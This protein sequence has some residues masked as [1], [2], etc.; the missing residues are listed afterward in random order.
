MPIAGATADLPVIRDLDAYFYVRHR[1][2]ALLVGAFEPDG[3][4]LDPASLP[5][6]FSFGE[7]EPDWDHFAPVRE[8]AEERIPALRGI[9]WARVPERAREFT[10]DADFCIGETGAVG[11]LYVAAGF[12]S[13][14]IMFAA[15]AGRALAEWIVAGTPQTTS[16]GST[17][18]ASRRSSRTA[19]TSTTRVKRGPRP[20]VRVALAVPAAAHGAQHP[21]DAAAR[22]GPKRRTPVRRDSSAGSAPTGMRRRRAAPEY[23]YSFGRQNWF[24]HAAAEHHAVRNAR[25]CIDLSTFTKFEVAG[26]DAL[27]VLQWICTKD[28]DVAV[29]RVVYTLMLNESGGIE[30]DGTVT[31]LAPEP[32]HRYHADAY[33]RPGLASAPARRRRPGGGHVRRDRRRSRQSPS[34]GRVSRELLQ[35]ISRT[36]LSNEALPWSH[37]RRIEVAD[38][39]AYCLRVCFI[40]ELGYELYPSADLALSLYDAVLEAGSGP[41]PA[42]V[43]LSRARLAA[44]GEGLPPPRPRHRQPR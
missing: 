39:Y 24:E 4:P 7:L 19:A 20:P 16:P 33:P 10:P 26:P 31:R 38:G 15:G 8:L 22:R 11:G 18:S 27:A 13:Q 17:S 40:G 9:E 30:I 1:D 2:G 5:A 44:G 6:G 35:R 29:G 42:A 36:D 21:P 14:G 37:G 32:V 41:R 12:N 28:L 25:R 23:V 3:K 43:R 34:P